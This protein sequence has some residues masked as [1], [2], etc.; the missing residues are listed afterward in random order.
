MQLL[1]EQTITIARSVEAAYQYA[2]N[3]ERFSEWFPG[4]LSIESV[5]ALEHAQ[6][7][8]E[9]LETVVVPLR[10]KRKIKISVKDAQSNKMFVTEGEFPPL[11]PRMEILFKAT[12]ADSCSITWRMFSRSKSFLFKATL[13]HLFKSIMHKRAAIG[14]KQLQQK[15]EVSVR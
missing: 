9:Y 14:L 11:M 1:T 4:V 12:G 8:K 3:L 2:T 13:L 5:N 15:L 7:G 6:R 10:G